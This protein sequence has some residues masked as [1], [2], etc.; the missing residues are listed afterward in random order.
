MLVEREEHLERLL[1]VQEAA[2][3]GRGR[4]VLVDGPSATG[5]TELLHAVADRAEAAG[6]RLLHAICAR[7]ER[8]HAL[9]VMHQLCRY[10]GIPGYGTP[11]GPGTDAQS[12][13]DLCAALLE[14]SAEVP[15]LIAVDDVQHAD[16]PSLR[17]L[18]HLSRRLRSARIV[19]LLTDNTD[20][21]SVNL[22]LRA[23]L[24]RET[25]LTRLRV[26][27]LGEAGIT[28]FL[29]P[30]LGPETAR[31][32][33]PYFTAA[34]GGNPLL[35]GA[36]ADDWEGSDGDE[37][38]GHSYSLALLSC[39]HR[40]DEAA[41][42]LA[43]ARAVLDTEADDD[44][45]AALAG[46]P[47]E[48]TAR[49]MAACGLLCEDGRFRHPAVRQAVLDDLSPRELSALHRRAARLLY[50]SGAQPGRVARHLLESG[51]ADEPWAVRV[52][53]EAADHHLLADRPGPA[54][55]CL[56]L[57]QRSSGDLAER[58]EILARL[59]HTE[60]QADP[61]AAARHLPQLVTAD[62]AGR[63]C[64]PES[65]LLVRQLLW[66]GRTEEAVDA[67]ER[68]RSGPAGRADASGEVADL[69]QWLSWAHPPLARPARP[70][71]PGPRRAGTGRAGEGAVVAMLRSE[72]WLGRTAAL[73]G[74]L[75][76]DHPEAVERAEQGLW[77]LRLSRSAY[78]S[79]EAAVLALLTL[80]HGDRSDSAAEWCERLAVDAAER[81]TPTWQAVFLAV[82]A[83]VAVRQGDHATAVERAQSALR[84]LPAKAWGV[85]IGLPLSSLIVATTRMGR[86]DEA[87]R[88]LSQA[89]PATMYESWYGLPF[90]QAR[91]VHHLATNHHRAA[92]GDFLSCGEL[93]RTW[94]IQALGPVPW[95]AGA[96]EACIRLGNTD[97]AKQLIH[98]QLTRPGASG[99]RT[100]GIA[101]RL[102]AATCA[103]GRG[104]QLLTE[105]LELLE[106]AGDRFEQARVLADMSRL[107]N[108]LGEQR[109]ARMLFR[110]S[111]HVAKA[112][113]ARPLTQE[114][115]A[116]SEGTASAVVTEPAPEHHRTRIDELTGS[117]MR[118]A[119]LAVMGYTNREI[120][121]K[122]F[123]TPSTVEQH[124]TRVYRK[125]K[126]QRRQDLPSDLW[127]NAS[128]AG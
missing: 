94:G 90:L 101:L 13:D 121:A 38:A 118:V 51:R 71:V 12:A 74:Q 41:L 30:R 68:I 92:L 28:A 85:A 75:V 107:Y 115:L 56:D 112:C 40:G 87:L 126:I 37:G 52:L 48:T 17:L 127:P 11:G 23:E 81:A 79:E 122:L 96:A 61:A 55:A 31:R 82:R 119:S 125:L 128:K 9:G 104:L 65:A 36:L 123:V 33:T 2:L 73:A 109:R 53:V 22:Q 6:F 114:L 70:T 89:V 39:L 108:A 24:L 16:E 91:G 29:T 58:A 54:A 44:T 49:A 69:E 1:R 124:L 4:M 45:L 117:E 57:A 120:A 72:P 78:W 67:L 25:G 116:G 14:R 95:R 113:E 103:P 50:D 86:Y 97:R 46:A 35:L 93:Q 59:A 20:V 110:Q 32:L 19:V 42:A 62:R 27:P 83:E 80:L 102:Y 66:H 84:S 26:G 8:T 63:L 7:P 10:A 47:V 5:K 111:L 60:F 98:E 43:R 105:A 18:L 15:L 100:R 64:F 21:P 34:T 76:R 77:D 88:H 3:A 106:S 99:G